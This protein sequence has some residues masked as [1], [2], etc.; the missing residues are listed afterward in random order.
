MSAFNHLASSADKTVKLRRKSVRFGDGYVQ[1]APDG[2]NFQLR[3]WAL[4]FAR[5]KDEA[6]AIEAFLLTVADGSGFDWTDPD[7]YAARWRVSDEGWKR[8]VN[9]QTLWASISVTFEE[10]PG[11]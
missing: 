7:G 5:P 11:L 10:A 8:S 4:T 2:L 9:Y 1:S 3:S 6:D